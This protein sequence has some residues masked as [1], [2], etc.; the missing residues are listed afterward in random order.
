MSTYFDDYLN[1]IYLVIWVQ[2]DVLFGFL[3]I[4]GPEILVFWYM[5][6]FYCCSSTAWWMQCCFTVNNILI[7]RNISLFNLQWRFSCKKGSIILNLRWPF[8]FRVNSFLCFLSFHQL[9]FIRIAIA[10]SN[11][12]SKLITQ[13]QANL[14]CLLLYL[15]RTRSYIILLPTW[16]WFP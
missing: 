2:W 12:I 11:I 7:N 13:P 3:Y 10:L 14:N 8:W 5:Y 1:Y 4:S 16:H 15:L 6:V 9:F